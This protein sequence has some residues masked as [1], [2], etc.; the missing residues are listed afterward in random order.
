MTASDSSSPTPNLNTTR[1][2]LNSIDVKSP[3][4]RNKQTKCWNFA[5]IHR[6]SK[7]RVSR[8][9]NQQ[10]EE[11]R[12]RRRSQ[13]HAARISRLSEH[14]IRWTKSS[15]MNLGRR[16]LRVL[17]ITDPTASN[18]FQKFNFVTPQ[19]QNISNTEIEDYPKTLI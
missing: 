4:R 18:D 9:I 17:F 3:Y 6:K 1:P 16:S 2:S 7:Q 13:L 5:N 10:T 11:L 8:H 19:I 12:S 15:E 14:K